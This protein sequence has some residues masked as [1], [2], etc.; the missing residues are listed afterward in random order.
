MNT[1][2]YFNSTSIF[3]PRQHNYLSIPAVA[4]DFGFVYE[5]R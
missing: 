4:D 3:F 5:N 2:A 1:L